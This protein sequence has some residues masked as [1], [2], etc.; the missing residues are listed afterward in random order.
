LRITLVGDV[1]VNFA[2]SMTQMELTEVK[3]SMLCVII[4]TLLYL[5]QSIYGIRKAFFQSKAGVSRYHNG[6]HL[7]TAVIPPNYTYHSNDAAVL[8]LEIT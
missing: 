6:D 4:C 2:S 8:D 5:S 3:K 7:S 1:A